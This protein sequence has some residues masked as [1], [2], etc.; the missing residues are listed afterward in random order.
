MILFPHMPCQSYTCRVDCSCEPV[1]V[2]GDPVHDA[3]LA[4]FPGNGSFMGFW[5]FLSLHSGIDFVI[6]ENISACAPDAEV[7]VRT[8]VNSA[9]SCGNQSVMSCLIFFLAIRF[10]SGHEHSV[11]DQLF[12]RTI[13][14]LW[15]IRRMFSPGVEIQV[16]VWSILEVRA[17]MLAFFSSENSL[18]SSVS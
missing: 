3:K 6:A 13:P 12:S 1:A 17:W 8:R 11:A 5:C 4:G 16:K 2:I 15:Y 7:A 9:L 10:Q 14:K 18:F